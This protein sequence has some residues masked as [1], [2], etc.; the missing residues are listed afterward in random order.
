VQ[1]Q[2]QADPLTRAAL[3]SAE[4]AT[5]RETGWVVVRG[6]LERAAVPAIASDVGSVLAA[7]NMPSSFLAQSSEYLAGSPIHRLVA[8]PRLATLAG[9]ALAGPAHLYMPFTA[10]KGPG[11]GEFTF[12]QDG[13]YTQFDGPG[14][15][16]WFALMR[17]TPANG[18]LRLVSGSHRQ[19]M[20]PWMESPRCPGHRTLV[21]VP[22][23]W[24]D[25]VM[26]PGDC[27]IFDRMTVHGSGAN[28]SADPRFAYA[29]Q[30]HRGDTRALIDGTWKT[31][32]ERPRY[33]TGP[34]ATL[35][36]AAQKGE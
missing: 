21:A 2:Q 6:L 33:A 8:S 23:V 9:Q 1:H 24:E 35:T 32:L 3:T 16:C 28:G 20:L 31:L 13:Q 27:C 25:A 34:V 10:V 29:V 5:Y 11:Q 4:L 15:N 17:C 18:G 12:H 36:S 30:F 19:G 26:E 7:R 22:V 14:L